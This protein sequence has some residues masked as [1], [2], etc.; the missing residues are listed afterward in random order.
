VKSRPPRSI[1]DLSFLG[2]ENHEMVQAHF[3]LVICGSDDFTWIVYG[4]ADGLLNGDDESEDDDDCAD[5]Y[6]DCEEGYDEDDTPDPETTKFEE[7]QILLSEVDS[8]TIQC[9]REYFARALEIRISQNFEES[10]DL[11][12]TLE[13]STVS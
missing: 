2:L 13:D 12:A 1:Q 9:P 7:D 11:V 4:C 5:D 8:T 6:H 10:S 3:S